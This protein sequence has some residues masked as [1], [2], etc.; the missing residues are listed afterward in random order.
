MAPVYRKGVQ[1]VAKTKTRK[2]T[3]IRRIVQAAFGLGLIGTSIAH[4]LI[5]EKEVGDL[6]VAE[7]GRVVGILSERDYARIE[8]FMALMTDKHIRHLL[9]LDD[10]Q[11]VGVVSIGDL[12]KEVI[13]E[14]EFLIENLQAY[15]VGSRTVR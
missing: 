2:V 7:A 10:N 9:V 14:Q 5:A 8:E 11:L 4:N 15:I 3:V 6:V 13:S 12:V 1:L